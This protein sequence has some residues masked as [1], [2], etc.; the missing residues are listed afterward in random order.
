MLGGMRNKLYIIFS[1]Y[2][3]LTQAKH[4]Y[5]QSINNTNNKWPAQK[6]GKYL[7]RK[8]EAR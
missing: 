5:N 4:C 6:E 2:I 8:L 1:Q 7:H 3:I